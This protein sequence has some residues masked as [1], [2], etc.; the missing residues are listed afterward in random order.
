[1]NIGVVGCGN[2]SD[3]YLQNAGRFDALKVTACADLDAAKATAKAEA[4]GV[5]RACSADELLADPAIELV[6]NLT[7]PQAHFEI[8]RKALEAGKHL[9]SE[10]PLALRRDD[11]RQL[12]D[13]ARAKNRRIGCAPDTFLG[14]GLQTGRK[15]MDAGEIGRP[16]A[17]AAFMLCRGH[18]RWHPDPEFF[19]Q[20]GGGPLFDMGPYYL[21]ALVSLLGPVARV[22]A[23]T[24]TTFPE[25]TITSEPKNGQRIPVNVPTHVAGILEFEAEAMC[26]LTM[27][28]D[29]WHH[30]LPFIEIYGVDGTLSLPDPNGF[31][32]AV[33]MQTHRGKAWRKMNSTHGYEENSRGV[34]LADMVRAIESDRPHRASAELAFHVLDVMESLHDSAREGRPVDVASRCEKPA[35]MPQGLVFGQIGD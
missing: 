27:S 31:G 33:R 32:G 24:Q 34:G 18:E 22:T 16:V 35:R 6:L 13:L 3:V 30:Q 12:L 2:I 25:R 5:P 10:K 7:P 4:Q 19:Y 11:G 1:M 26:T 28:F 14:A 8:S 15:L 29:V 20:P 17:A 23:R 9:Y 21:T